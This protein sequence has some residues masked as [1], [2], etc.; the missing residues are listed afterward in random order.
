M[1][2]W[3]L[4][5]LASV[6]GVLA[7]IVVP[8][9]LLRDAR[10]WIRRS[11]A[12]TSG[13][14]GVLLGIWI[15][16]EILM[17]RAGLRPYERTF[18]GELANDPKNVPWARADP[19]LGWTAAPGFWGTNQQGFR[20]RR[21][22][23]ALEPSS[24]KTR[25]MVLGDSFVWGSR[26]QENE[27]L[28]VLLEQELGDEYECFSVGAPGWG[29]DQMVLA[30]ER[31]AERMS[32]KVVILAFIDD[33]VERV[34]EAYRRA[35]CMNKPCF[36]IRDG[37]LVPQD[38]PTGFELFLNRIAR[39]S[40]FFGTMLRSAYLFTDAKPVVA[41][42]LSKLASDTAR[43][44]GRLV[45][46]RIPTRN[47]ATRSGSIRRRMVSCAGAVEA[48]GARYLDAREELM[49]V[50]GWYSDFYVQ[51][52][53]LSVPGQRFMAAYLRRHAFADPGAR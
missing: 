34:L 11:V 4:L 46:L 1:G 28:P 9:R 30:H 14:I 18:P 26:V 36:E 13:A 27:T 15:P 5:T 20:D 52:G 41:R 33:D 17:R 16:G 8:L 31:F 44:G 29:I 39:K 49:Q 40:V 51:D 21:D 24:S 38:S 45:V 53:H 22:Y 32:P 50:P 7:T 6:A 35:E 43:T 23:D 42:L 19:V 2:F 25:V 3:I 37:A 48:A 12:G 10:P 47:D